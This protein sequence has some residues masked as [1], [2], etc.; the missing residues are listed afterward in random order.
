VAVG[1]GYLDG[2]D[3]RTWGADLV[4]DTVAEFAAVLGLPVHA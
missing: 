2:G 1:W 3:P 4:V